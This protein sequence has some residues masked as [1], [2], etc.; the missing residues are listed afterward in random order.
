MSA[1]PQAV[2]RLTRD[3]SNAA[4]ELGDDAARFLVDTYYSIQEERIRAN[5][6]IRA[7][8]EA[9]EP[10]D[11]LDWLAENAHTLEKQI[12]RALNR[13]AL[14]RPAGQ[15]AMAQ[16]GVGPVLAAGL[17]AHIDFKRAV[18]AGA[19][20]RFAGLDPSQKWEK[21]QRRPWNARLKVIAWKLG[22]SFVKQAGREGCF[23]GHIYV[24]RKALEQ[25]KN[26]AGDYADQAEHILATRKIGKTT[27][28]YAHYAA[29]RLP[30]AQIHARAKRYAVKLFLS[31]LH[32]IG[33]RRELHKAPPV[34]YAVGALQHAH[35]IEPPNG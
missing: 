27:D 11:V 6:Q 21:G 10:V 30:P 2:Q 29:G 3:L 19:V 1:A 4:G 34:P 20:W 32:E 14:S 28:A 18:T 17:L 31:H 15:W 8:T 33:W 7:L 35:R 12:K 5:N 23:Y 9:G 26:E 13:Y 22:E 24:E 25:A 16:I